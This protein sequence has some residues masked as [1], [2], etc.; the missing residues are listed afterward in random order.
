MSFAEPGADMTP[1]FESS[2]QDVQEEL[3]RIVRSAR[4]RR[5]ARVVLKGSAVVLLAALVLAIVSVWGMDRFKFSEAS[6]LVFRWLSYGVI[7]GL[8]VRFL[9]LPLRRRVTDER[10]ALYLEEHEP[11]LEGHVVSALET[12][13]DRAAAHSRILALKVAE[14]A[15]NRLH[16]VDDGRRIDRPAIRRSG[17]VLAGATLF[18]LAAFLLGPAFLR[19]GAPYL[20][21]RFG[22]ERPSPYSIDVT[23]GSVTLPRGADLQIQARLN[24][25]TADEVELAVRRGDSTWTRFP[26]LPDSGAA[27][28][29]ELFD[30]DADAEYFV[31]AAGVRSPLFRVSVAD[32][33]AVSGLELEYR[34]PAYTGLPVQQQQDD[35]DIAA[36]AGTA[37]EIRITT[38]LP[39]PGGVLLMNG[40]DSLA[41]ESV[42]SVHLAGRINV[43]TPGS[44]RILLNAP[45]AGWINASPDYVIDVLEDQ[46]PIVTVVKPGRD[47]TVTSIEEVFTEVTAQD[48]Y[49]VRRLELVYSVNGGPEKVVDLKAGGR[50]DVSG[51]HTLYLEEFGLEAGDLVSY[52]ARAVDARAGS[53]QSSASDIYFMK[54]RAFD[55]EYRQ[56]DQAGQPGQPQEGMGNALS[57]RQKDI[58]AATFR[59][60]RDK[61]KY[62]DREWGE[63]LATVALLQGRLRE[64]VET[65]LGRM[66]S[67]GVAAMD[68]TFVTI[69]QSLPVAIEAM[70]SG[71]A[72]LTL[73]EPQEALPPE[74]QSLQFLQRA[75]EAYKQIEIQQQQGGGGGG[76]GGEQRDLADLFDLELDRM[77]NQY[78]QV[79]RGRQQTADQ[80]VDEAVERLKELARRQQQQNERMQAR[81]QAQGRQQQA[82]AGGGGGAQRQLAQEADELARRLERLARERRQPDLARTAQQLRDAAN[83]MRRAAGGDPRQGNAQGQAAL[84]RMRQA[85]RQLEQTQSGRLERDVGDLER[86][87]AELAEQQKSVARDAAGLGAPGSRDQESVRRLQQQKDQMAG[88][89]DDIEK[90]LD[91]LSR[92]SRGEQREASRKL[93]EAAEAMRQSRLRE[94]VLFSRGLLDNGAPNY[95][96]AFENQITQ[97]L[98]GLKERIEQ[99]QSAI[100]ANPGQQ[101]AGALDRTRDLV[102][103]MESMGDRLDAERR[104]GQRQ[105][106]QDGQ[107][108][109]GQTGQQQ[110]GQ[111]GRQEGGQ[112]AQGQPQGA[113]SDAGGPPRTGGGRAGDLREF[114]RELEARRQDL[115]GLR[116]DLAGQGVDVSDL[117][118]MIAGLS[119]A[120][121]AAGAGDLNAV[122]ALQRQV[123]Q[124]LKDFEFALRRRIG[125]GG[126]ER[127]YLSGSDDV[128]PEY[129]TQVEEYYRGLSD[130]GARQE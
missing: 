33:P 75:E 90:Q 119:R 92:E 41:L 44:Y 12:G 18:G 115:Q 130:G 80:Q 82:Q 118:R 30:L 117:D 46:P 116:R 71:E 111:G 5:Q 95:V 56:S 121:Q 79:Q 129:R 69:A 54:V 96:E 104:Q 65:L 27:W 3:R 84:E 29:L 50:K 39:A 37:V 42:D 32:L 28:S 83:A 15:V 9:I 74:Q 49:G 107:Q 45:R 58:I 89:L 127:L 51:A 98:E 125:S 66:R 81:A 97:G 48:D 11:S 22:G 85:Q 13:D 20:F 93:Q 77:Q 123:V 124:S 43:R 36:L 120:R 2:H 47:V 126:S 35:G 53:P 14:L 113:P 128:P 86:R 40:N 72:K 112:A 114:E 19:Q 7:A 108:Q 4:R 8:V 25:Y 31:E 67:R 100:R 59:L 34:F 16:S 88:E 122:A 78:E 91:R 62:S 105:D 52:Y 76:Q 109:E 110:D 106:G 63:N 55:K 73:R 60:V 87:A 23:P 99:A 68:S 17:G 24:N 26:M 102:N 21:P 70:K 61:D 1:S 101:M 10:I 6:I 64:E 57:S 38:T 94:R 103:A